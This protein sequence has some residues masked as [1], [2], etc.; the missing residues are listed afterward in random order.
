MGGEH[1]HGQLNDSLIGLFIAKVYKLDNY[2]FQAVLLG[3]CG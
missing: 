1:G 3:C 2:L